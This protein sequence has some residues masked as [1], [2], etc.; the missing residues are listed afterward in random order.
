MAEW[1]IKSY[2]LAGVLL[3][4]I[5]AL[6]YL[7]VGSLATEYNT[8]GIVDSGFS[9]RYDRFENQ[10]NT[11]THMWDAS[12]NPEAFN[13]ITSSIEVFK[14]AVSVIQLVFGGVGVIKDQIKNTATDFGIPP[15]IFNILSVLLIVTLSVLIIWGVINFMNK[16]GPI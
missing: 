6:S 15:A 7:M 11:I 14:G 3:S 10:T 16:T 2:V 9:D 8:P 5:I 13:P 12:S 1:T 4:A